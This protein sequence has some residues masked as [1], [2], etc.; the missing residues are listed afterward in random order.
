[1]ISPADWFSECCYR[2]RIKSFNNWL[3]DVYAID[4]KA[5]SNHWW[6][7]SATERYAIGGR[8]HSSYNN[9]MIRDIRTSPAEALYS[10]QCLNFA[11]IKCCIL[12]KMNGHRALLTAQYKRYGYIKPYINPEFENGLGLP[13]FVLSIAKKDFGHAINA[14]QIHED[15]SRMESYVFF[16]RANWDVDSDG[17][18]SMF[19]AG[20]D[21][22]VFNASHLVANYGTGS[23]GPIG[24][25]EEET[26]ILCR[27]KN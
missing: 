14:I 23:V 3:E 2:A 11:I 20:C 24:S 25:N 18:Y 10:P 8:L 7:L 4:W 21:V 1:M 27:F 22:K 17:S 5:L 19:P 15:Y 12:N 13:V 9:V 26:I 6:A 16:D